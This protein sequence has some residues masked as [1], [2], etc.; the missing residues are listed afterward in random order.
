MPSNVILE[1]YNAKTAD[2]IEE[3]A[4]DNEMKRL[5]L[6]D[7]Q[8]KIVAD[9]KQLALIHFASLTAN[10][11]AALAL[12]CE[13]G[14]K[15]GADAASGFA[16]KAEAE[17]VRIFL[18]ITFGSLSVTLLF[19]SSKDEMVLLISAFEHQ[20]DAVNDIEKQG[21]EE[22]IKAA[23]AE[24]AR[25]LTDA[26]ETYKRTVNKATYECNRDLGEVNRKIAI[27]DAKYKVYFPDSANPFEIIEEIV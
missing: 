8:A 24:C 23:K 25:A 27:I 18:K 12:R 19:F 6:A 10:N 21:I 14:A 22:E 7:A 4:W 2:E 13:Q 20:Q 11:A 15:E 1:G 3:I 17:K 5:D 16:D 9:E 26:N